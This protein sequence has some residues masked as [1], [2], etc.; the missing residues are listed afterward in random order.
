MIGFC[1]FA[2]VN[3]LDCGTKETLDCFR[4]LR[5][6]SKLDLNTLRCLLRAVMC[7]SKEHW[8][9]F[10]VLFAEYWQNRERVRAKQPKNAGK[11]RPVLSESSRKTGLRV[12]APSSPNRDLDT[13]DQAD[14]V[15]GASAIEQLKRMDFAAVSPDNLAELERLSHRLLRRLSWQVSMKL[16][17]KKDRGRIDLRRTIRRNL[18]RGGDLIELSHKKRRRQ[19]ARL[20]IF[21]DV[22]DSMNRYSVF[23]L[24]F[25]YVLR[26]YGPRVAPFIFSTRVVEVGDVLKARVW[27]DVLEALSG[28]TTG[29]SGG[30][31]IGRCLFEFN[32][33]YGAKLLSRNTVFVILSDGWDTEPPA[34]LLAELEKV[35]S[36]VKQLIWLNPLL[37]LKDYQPVT[38][39]MNA[40]LPYVDV[41]APAHNLESLL[42]LERY[43]RPIT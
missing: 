10:D 38:R 2:R 31:K 23:L 15:S 26:R 17:P 36:R 37:G 13:V 33:L 5:T 29:W 1:R 28:M 16:Q 24:K 22:S 6:I 32:R 34:L 27:S 7:S 11:S 8:D 41:F 30:T 4:A 14:V 40:A 20:V 42:Q 3:G 19:R 35:K 9:L 21:L 25:A 12:F 43:L 18:S 39:A